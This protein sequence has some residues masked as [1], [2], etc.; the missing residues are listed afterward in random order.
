MFP[1]SESK[2]LGMLFNSMNPHV[3]IRSWY[4]GMV[5]RFVAAR[6]KPVRA[7]SRSLCL[8][9]GLQ[10]R[11]RPESRRPSG[12]GSRTCSPSPGTCPGGR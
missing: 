3:A 11:L 7:C 4:A 9:L 2:T 5:G 10:Q 8:R 1:N 12:G 6:P